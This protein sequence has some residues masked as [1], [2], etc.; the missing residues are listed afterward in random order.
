MKTYNFPGW[1]ARVDGKLVPM[2]SDQDG[3]QLVEVPPGIHTVEA[4]FKNTPPR[5]AGTV[6]SAVGLLM[7]FGL[8]FAGRSRE[9]KVEGEGPFKEKQAVVYSVLSAGIRGI[10]WLKGLA[11]IVLVIVAGAAAIVMITRRSNPGNTDQPGNSA[12]PSVAPA[13]QPVAGGSQ[14]AGSDAQLYLAGRDSVMVALDEKAL[15]EM[16][17]AISTRDQPALDALIESGRALKAD[18][19]TR[20]RVLETTTGRTKVR[21]REGPHV[22]AEGWVPE[23]WLR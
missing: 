1:T 14:G 7:V 8:S 18:N 6:I 16:L 13:D 2:L 9:R 22:L 23:R 21:I 19:N 3:V 12:A 15:D 5:T 11:A 17:S 20:V 10:S 4:S